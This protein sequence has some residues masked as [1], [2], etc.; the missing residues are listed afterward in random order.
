MLPCAGGNPL[1]V[2]TFGC[3]SGGRATPGYG[4]AA[5]ARLERTRVT[6]IRE[7]DLGDTAYHHRRLSPE[8]RSRLL[9][10]HADSMRVAALG[11]RWQSVAPTPLW[12]TPEAC[13]RGSGSVILKVGGM[14]QIREK[15]RLGGSAHPV[16]PVVRL[17]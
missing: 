2:A 1:R 16:F 9:E 8:F 14:P 10:S 3:P 17:A 15:S 12:H 4:W 7:H 6:A 5:A 13:G 11:V